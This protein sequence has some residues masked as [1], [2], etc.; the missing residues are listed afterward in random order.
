M[1]E[2]VSATGGV[3]SRTDPQNALGFQPEEEPRHGLDRARRAAWTLRSRFAPPG[4][5]HL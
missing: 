1:I 5:G 2:E 3:G 4:L